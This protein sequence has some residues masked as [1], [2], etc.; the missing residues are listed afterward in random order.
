MGKWKV[1]LA[2]GRKMLAEIKIQ[3]DISQR[4]SLLTLLFVLI[5]MPLNH[6]LRKCVGGYKFTKS[7]E[8]I[9]HF[10]NMDYLRYLPKI[11]KN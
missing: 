1:E 8:K 11:T 10:M 9:N 4:D 5:M 6:I 2:A 3:R 7:K